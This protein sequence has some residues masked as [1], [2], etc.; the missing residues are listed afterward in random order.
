MDMQVEIAAW[1]NETEAKLSANQIT[2]VYCIDGTQQLASKN[3]QLFS[4][5]QSL[6]NRYIFTW[7]H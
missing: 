5:N 4:L 6:D 2:K 3:T 7:I 1:V